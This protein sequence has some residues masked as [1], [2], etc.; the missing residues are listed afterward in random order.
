M[1]KICKN[2]GKVMVNNGDLNPV[3]SYFGVSKFHQHWVAF[4]LLGIALVIIGILAIIGGNFAALATARFFGTLLL[5]AGLM[6][7]IYVL[8]G[9]AGQGF[10]QFLL[11]SVFYSIVG[12]LL[13]T[14]PEAGALAL[15][16]LFAALFTVTGVFKIIFSLSI[17]ILQWGW[18]LVSGIVSLILGIVLWSA[19]AASIPWVLGL[20]IGIDL[21][22]LGL[23]WIMLSL[24]AKKLPIAP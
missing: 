16:I 5:I 15:T 22:F 17:P 6:Q 19:F 7:F 24:A 13:I 21:L 18:L 11:A 2:K 9:R 10:S 14:Y 23:H 20:F 1:S 8:V 3:E 4:L 12:I